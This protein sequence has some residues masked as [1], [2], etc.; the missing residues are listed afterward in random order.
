MSLTPLVSSV[1]CDE[2]LSLRQRGSPPSVREACHGHR[3]DDAVVIAVEDGVTDRSCKRWKPDPQRRIKG[4]IT[5][6]P[7]ACDLELE[8]PQ[9]S[10]R[11]D[12]ASRPAREAD[13]FVRWGKRNL[14][15]IANDDAAPG[16]G[17][18]KLVTA[19]LVGTTITSYRPQPGNPA[20]DAGR[21]DAGRACTAG[22]AD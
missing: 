3:R 12:P 19:G 4:T 22:F 1:R 2:R 7:P 8:D 6:Q 14:T 20:A 9:A 5:Q 18:G 17:T 10:D 13:E 15:V 16:R 11:K 21:K